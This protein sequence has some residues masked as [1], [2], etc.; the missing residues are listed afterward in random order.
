MPGVLH[1]FRFLRIADKGPVGVAVFITPPRA[2]LSAFLEMKAAPAPKRPPLRPK[3]RPHFSDDVV[4]IAEPIHVLRT[5]AR[6]RDVLAG[7]RTAARREKTRFAARGPNGHVGFLAQARGD[8]FVVRFDA[9]DQAA[10]RF[11]APG[12][13]RRRLKSERSCAFPIF[14][15]EASLKVGNRAGARPSG[16]PP[17][18][19]KVA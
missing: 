8:L 17:P 7:I 14:L 6:R 11:A 4:I 1:S 3:L 10:A 9:L 13:S 12:Q 18:R 16:V 19:P 2:Q 5:S 15:A